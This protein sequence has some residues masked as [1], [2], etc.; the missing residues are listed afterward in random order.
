VLTKEF[1]CPNIVYNECLER[2][3][4]CGYPC[5]TPLINR[6][7]GKETL[8]FWC[9]RCGKKYTL[10]QLKKRL[11]CQP[12]HLN[13]QRRKQDGRNGVLA[14]NRSSGSLFYQLPGEKFLR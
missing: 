9:C 4:E 3:Q 8:L 10:E 7:R 12:E 11:D 5:V 6:K 13:R 2:H 14:S 1:K